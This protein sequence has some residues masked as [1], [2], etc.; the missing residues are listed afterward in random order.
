V[1]NTGEQTIQGYRNTVLIPIEFSLT[2]SRSHF[3]N[4]SRAGDIRI[5]G[6]VYSVFGNFV[7]TPIYRGELIKIGVLPLKAI[8]GDYVFLWQI[9]CEEGGFP[10]DEQYGKINVKVI[11]Y[12]DF[13][14]KATNGT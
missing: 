14:S 11:S 8:L 3:G 10:A 7:S 12:D 2:S 5:D 6:R 4:L 1:K 13:L 9:R